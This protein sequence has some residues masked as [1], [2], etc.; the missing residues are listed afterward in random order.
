MWK[1]LLLFAV[2]AAGFLLAWRMG[3][4]KDDA[5]PS[6]FAG[7]VRVDDDF[8]NYRRETF[9]WTILRGSDRHDG[10]HEVFVKVF[11]R[12]GRLALCG[13]L[14]VRG[15]LS[16]MAHDWLQEARLELG[17]YRFRTRFINAQQPGFSPGDA[18]AGCII[19][20][21]AFDPDLRGAPISFSGPPVQV[22][23]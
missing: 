6:A 15:G 5:Q 2:I 12:D 11:E 4:I 22:G 8:A 3:W 1:P 17:G 7:L 21:L 23:K 10:E 16:L 14:L 18:S 9:R 19:T 13:Y 20:Q